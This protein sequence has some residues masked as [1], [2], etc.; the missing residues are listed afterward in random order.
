MLF[1]PPKGGEITLTYAPKDDDT[2]VVIYAIIIYQ[3]NLR[4]LNKFLS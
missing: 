3:V 4:L 2:R 1:S